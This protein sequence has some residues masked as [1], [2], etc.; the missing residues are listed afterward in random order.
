M[1]DDHMFQIRAII[2]VLSQ[3]TRERRVNWTWDA[4]LGSVTATLS[5]GR[6]I[7]SK[8]SDF[9]TVI[10][11]EDSD[12]NNL[13]FINVGFHGFGDLQLEADELYDL[14]RHSALQID[15]KLE[16]ILREIS[17]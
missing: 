4:E 3:R 16:S 15:S 1:N 9:D 6:V 12:S 10:E 11:I 8:D 5:N 7:V 2:N 17:D 13:E 14:A